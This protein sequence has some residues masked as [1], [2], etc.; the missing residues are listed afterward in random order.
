M[1]TNNE[2][3]ASKAEIPEFLLEMSKQM[4]EQDSRGASNPIW[5]VCYDDYL[6]TTDEINEVSYEIYDN[7]IYGDGP[8]YRELIDDRDTLMSHVLAHYPNELEAWLEE[9]EY[10]QEEEPIKTAIEW[11]DDIDDFVNELG[12]SSL[13]RL[14]LQKVTREVR[15]CL[16]ESDANSFID[17]K[18][19]DFPP[20]YTVV[21]SMEHCPQMVALRTWVQ[22]LT[23]ANQ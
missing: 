15:Y 23:G 6:A 16:T 4:N 17:R 19:H 13:S 2:L 5:V 21:K 10:N 3:Q 20:L 18:S 12:V 22:S 1:I 11:I 9:H 14:G 7:D 8:I